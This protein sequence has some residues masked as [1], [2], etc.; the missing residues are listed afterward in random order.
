[1]AALTIQDLQGKNEELEKQIEGL[2]D[3]FS[4]IQGMIQYNSMLIEELKAKDSDESKKKS[5]KK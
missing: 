3:A 5:K 4:R 2:K 1:M